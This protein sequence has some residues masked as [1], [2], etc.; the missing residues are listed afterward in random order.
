LLNDKINI[1][2]VNNKKTN[3]VDFKMSEKL[4][5]NNYI[6]PHLKYKNLQPCSLIQKNQFVD[7]YTVLSYLEAITLNSLEIVK[8]KIKKKDSK[9]IL[10]ISNK[11]CLTL[12]KTK[13]L[14]KK[15]NDFI[16]TS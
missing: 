15:L 6:S 11:D 10:L 3:S 8:F 7:S 9:Q 12:E 13:F 5:L 2:L 16:V 4:N 1:E 14:N